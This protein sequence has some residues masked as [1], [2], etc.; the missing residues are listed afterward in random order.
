MR[1]ENLHEGQVIKNYKELCDILEVEAKQN[2]D[3][4]A[5]KRHHEEFNRYFEYEKQGQKYII[6]RIFDEP[7]EKIE[8]RGGNNL[9]YTDILSPKELS[10]EFDGFYVY[11]HILNDEVIY[12]GK[13]CKRRVVDGNRQYSMK[14]IKKE[15]VKRFDNEFEALRFE[16]NLI[17]YYKSIGQCRYNGE[18]YVPGAIASI[19]D[20]KLKPKPTKDKEKEAC[21]LL[22]ELGYQFDKYK[23][24][25]M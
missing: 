12:I 11:R 10:N 7:K 2:N 13:G 8:K 21:E 14:D 3:T 5:R 23:G 17:K 1:V 25:Y 20:S 4:R 15:I 19:K 18:V 9:K 24:W 6:T 22:L 16:E